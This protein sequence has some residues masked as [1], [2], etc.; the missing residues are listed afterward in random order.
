MGQSTRHWYWWWRRH[1][2]PYGW[3]LIAQF[4]PISLDMMPS[5]KIAHISIRSPSV[6]KEKYISCPCFPGT[7]L[8]A[9]GRSVLPI[10][11]LKYLWSRYFLSTKPGTS[12]SCGV[13]RPGVQGR[14]GSHGDSDPWGILWL[15]WFLYSTLGTHCCR[16][17]FPPQRGFSWHWMNNWI[18]PSLKEIFIWALVKCDQRLSA[19][20]PCHLVPPIWHHI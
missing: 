14:T 17:S 20:A 18:F 5:V 4:W 3:D 12:V 6:S 7:T 16:L 10:L 8:G 2:I 1:I 11:A 15:L 13:V 19:G 9:G